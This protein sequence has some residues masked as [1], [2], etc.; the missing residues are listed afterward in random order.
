MEK[1]QTKKPKDPNA[2]EK[3]ISLRLS[4]KE[5]NSLKDMADKYADGNLNALI[6]HLLFKAT[7]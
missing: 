7:K 2:R 4:D 5:L 3:I 1:I 6:R